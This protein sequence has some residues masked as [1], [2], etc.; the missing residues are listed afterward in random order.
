MPEGAAPAGGA[1]AA[2]PAIP[3]AAEATGNTTPAEGAEGL[4]AERTYSTEEAPDFKQWKH[5]LPTREGEEAE[6]VDYE[7]L[8]RGHMRQ[9]DYTRGKQSIAQAKKQYEVTNK[10]ANVLVNRLNSAEGMITFLHNAGF[11]IGE[12]MQ[13]FN[14]EQQ[15]FEQL[16]VEEQHT[17]SL[18]QQRQ[19]HEQQLRAEQQKNAQAQ[20]QH[21]V[22]SWAEPIQRWTG[23]AL[24]AANLPF[25][26]EHKDMLEQQLVPLFKQGHR[27]I[28]QD[29]FMHAAK[30]LDQRLSRYAQRRGMVKGAP[31]QAPPSVRPSQGSVAAGGTAK[32]AAAQGK[33]WSGFQAKMKA[34]RQGG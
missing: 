1:E 15:A 2:A 31:K 22:K 26:Q 13:M 33:S 6:E 8:V 11:P 18:E 14:R 19:Q 24:K 30:Q 17:R 29:D 3:G 21:A 32:G 34:I 12:A 20:Q 25:D 7:D 27:R 10:H 23:E 9:R 16:P 5:T 28:S 4:P